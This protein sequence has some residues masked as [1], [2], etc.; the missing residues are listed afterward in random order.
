MLVRK[1]LILT[2]LLAG[3]V[4]TVHAQ[5]EVTPFFGTRF[6]GNIDF[7]QISNSVDHVHLKSSENFGGMFDYGFWSTFQAEF[8]WNR[9][10]TSYTAFNTDGTTTFLTNA[11]LDMYQFSMVYQFRDPERKLRPF[12][13]AGLGF[14]HFGASDVLGFGSRFSYN[15]G[16]GVKY[17]FSKHVG[18]RIETRYSP[19]RTTT[20]QGTFCD[21]FFGCSTVAV[22]NH[23]Q[24]GQANLGLIFR[25]K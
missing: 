24:Q 15:I 10:P 22:S 3:G 19:S 20:G 7:S 18:L 9:Q 17:Y 6:G 12:A 5:V 13:V 1:M 8:M 25:F 11:N 4:S 23:A 2:F 21:P 14:T 16:G